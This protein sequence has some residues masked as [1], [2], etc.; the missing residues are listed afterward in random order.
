MIHDSAENWKNK[1]KSVVIDERSIQIKFLS[2]LYS[3][4]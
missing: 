2:I 4:M 1:S 3:N